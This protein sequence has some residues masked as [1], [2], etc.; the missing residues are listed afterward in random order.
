M[1]R[2][3]SGLCR[4]LVNLYCRVVSILVIRGGRLDF[5]VIERIYCFEKVVM[6]NHAL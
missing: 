3:I 5:M 4:A 6:L 1:D 2:E